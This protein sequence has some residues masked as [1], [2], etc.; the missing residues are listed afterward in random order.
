MAVRL[1]KPQ[2]QVEREALQEYEARG[3]KLTDAERRRMLVSF[4]QRARAASSA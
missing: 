4:D 2:R 1:A 3:S